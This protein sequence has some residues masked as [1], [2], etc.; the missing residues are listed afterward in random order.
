M[1]FPVI[2]FLENR[3]ILEILEWLSNISNLISFLFNQNHDPKRHFT[4][5]S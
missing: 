5:F 4:E 3:M 2:N 1:D